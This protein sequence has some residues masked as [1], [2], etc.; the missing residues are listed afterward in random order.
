MVADKGASKGATVFVNVRL[1]VTTQ[2]VSDSLGFCVE[3]DHVQKHTA[4]FRLDSG[5]ISGV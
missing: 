4:P 2:T 3:K 1:R 5:K